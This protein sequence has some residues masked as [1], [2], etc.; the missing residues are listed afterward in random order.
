LAERPAAGR[1]AT[2]SIVG[3]TLEYFDFAVYNMLA[4][5]VF[6]K[7]FFLRSIRS[8]AR[9]SLSRRS[10]SVTSRARSAE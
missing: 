6:N 8:P 4:A 9:C 10:P 1:L 5:L 2:A 7:L 3:T